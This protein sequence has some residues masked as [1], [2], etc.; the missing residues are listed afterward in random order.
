[1]KTKLFA[2][3]LLATTTLFSC[4]KNQ[5]IE[6]EEE[7][8]ISSGEEIRVKNGRL[9]FKNL[10]SF[11]K[12]YFDFGN[13]PQEEQQK[14]AIQKGIKTLEKEINESDSENE[15]IQKMRDVSLPPALYNILNSFGEFQIGEEIV[16]TDG[17]TQH[18]VKNETVLS[19]LKQNPSLSKKFSKITVSNSIEKNIPNAKIIL[20]GSQSS[21]LNQT[22]YSVSG[23]QFKNVFEIVRYYV[24][25]VNQNE[26]FILF[27]FEYFKQNA[28]GSGGTWKPAGESRKLSYNLN[29]KIDNGNVYNYVI[30]LITT[31]GQTNLKIYPTN[32]N[33]ATTNPVSF[34]VTGS[35]YQKADPTGHV[36][37]SFSN[38]TIW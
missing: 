7:T 32:F 4:E 36:A 28:I 16:W 8:T 22:T 18:I 29:V 5:I 24:P 33:P 3:V 15:Y 26:A 27:K 23:T 11:S 2:L 17:M 14:W 9:V 25:L 19:G 37:Y 13:L 12:F 6:N 21:A 10:D 31:S 1:M 20:T 30:P 38:T 34:D 35:I